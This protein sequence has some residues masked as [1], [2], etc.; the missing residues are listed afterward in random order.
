MPN[1]NGQIGW[2]IEAAKSLSLAHGFQLTPKYH[3]VDSVES[4][5]PFCRDGTKRFV[6]F[7]EG[8]YWCRECNTK[9][10]WGE[11]PTQEEVQKAL[12]EKELS[13]Q[14]TVRKLQ[15]CNDWKMYHNQVQLHTQ[16]WQAHGIDDT[17]IIKWQ[18]GY[19]EPSKYIEVPSLTI[20]IFFKGLLVDIRHRL[21]GVEDGQKYRSHFTNTPPA[22]FNA[23]SIFTNQKVFL[24]EGEKKAIIAHKFGYESAVSYPGVN[25]QEPLLA[26]LHE[27]SLSGQDIIYLPDPNTIDTIIAAGKEL[28]KLGHKVSVV[29]L[30]LKPDDLLLQ[31]G[32]TALKNALRYTRKL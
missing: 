23:D 31:Y 6:I 29:D 20:P 10:W 19:A 16:E 25:M 27:N 7:R 5:C 8:N 2:A 12:E 1:P 4:A 24:V 21:L 11:A 32:T 30:F 18:L 9:G 13:R 22:F 14:A 17:D 28:K 3:T 26:F 15:K